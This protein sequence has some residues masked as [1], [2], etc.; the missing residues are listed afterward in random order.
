MKN[1]DEL[2]ELIEKIVESA[3]GFSAEALNQ[4]HAETSSH[5]W[6]QNKSLEDRILSVR[7]TVSGYRIEENH[8]SEL[9]K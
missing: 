8:R 6:C 1:K 9:Y 5:P 3:P 7:F 4:L 2:D